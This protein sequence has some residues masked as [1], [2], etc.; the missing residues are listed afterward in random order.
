MLTLDPELHRR[1]VA[2]HKA[3]DPNRLASETIRE[4]LWTGVNGADP[5]SGVLIAARKLGYNHAKSHALSRISTFFFEL[6]REVY[7]LGNQADAD[8]YA[9]AILAVQDAER[10]KGN[11][12]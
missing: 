9:Q 4:L 12:G 8:A 6:S 2:Y 7:A 1:I 10:A 5:T 3:V 11:N